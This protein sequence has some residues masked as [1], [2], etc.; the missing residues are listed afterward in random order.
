MSYDIK[1]T[2]YVILYVILRF[3]QLAIKINERCK[4]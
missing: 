1:N 4:G 2:F 3:S